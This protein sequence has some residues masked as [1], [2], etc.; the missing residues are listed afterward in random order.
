MS[1]INISEENVKLFGQEAILSFQEKRKP[2]YNLAYL[3]SKFSNY[4][5]SNL[6]QNYVYTFDRDCETIHSSLLEND[7]NCFCIIL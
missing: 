5:Q 2:N 7:K 1:S 6:G 3:K 4:Q